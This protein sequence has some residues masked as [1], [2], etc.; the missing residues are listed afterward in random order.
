MGRSKKE[1]CTFCILSA[2][3]AR[4]LD[5]KRHFKYMIC[6]A[7]LC[8]IQNTSLKGKLGNIG[9]YWERQANLMQEILTAVLVT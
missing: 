1:K 9:K 5:E 7:L 2:S 4:N 8:F 6:S 3:L